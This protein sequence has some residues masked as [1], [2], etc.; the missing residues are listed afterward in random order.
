MNV[1]TYQHFRVEDFAADAHFSRWVHFQHP[2]DDEFWNRVVETYPKQAFAIREAKEIILL[3]RHSY[4]EEA[5]TPTEKEVM[6]GSMTER[7]QPEEALAISTPRSIQMPMWG[8]AAVIGLL[9]LGTVSLYVGLFPEKD[10]VYETSFGENLTIDLPDGSIVRLNAN[11]RITFPENWQNGEDRHVFLIGEGYFEVQKDLACMA[12]FSVHTDDLVV[13]V[14]GTRFNV[15]SRKENT[16]VVLNEGRIDL[17]LLKAEQ[18]RIQLSPGD[19]IN[20]KSQGQKWEQ[21][22][23]DPELHTSWKEGVQLF[24]ETSLKEIIVKMEE[25]YG[26]SIRL[27][28]QTLS[29]RKMTIGI[30]V[31]DLGIA[32]QTIESVLGLDIRLHTDNE[33]VI[34]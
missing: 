8:W 31:E 30:P 1:E 17:L 23:V 19:M 13:E 25:I 21:V 24:R 11:S 27:N 29:T 4:G 12:K 28:D 6:L 33:Y 22:K 10:Q 2:D 9:L 5:L 26:V 32:L 3:A 16:Q 34:Y 7:M 20:Y 18:Q 15:N 14:L